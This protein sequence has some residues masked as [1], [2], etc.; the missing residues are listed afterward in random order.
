MA[1]V[2]LHRVIDSV[3]AASPWS[4]VEQFVDDVVIQTI[5]ST[6]QETVERH[7]AA[8]E[9]FMQGVAKLRCRVSTKSQVLGSNAKL[10]QALGTR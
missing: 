1:R 4:A 6:V 7:M 10:K 3:I 8:S 2:Y 9:S 5:G